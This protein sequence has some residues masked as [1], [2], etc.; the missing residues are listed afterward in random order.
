MKNQIL[1]LGFILFLLPNLLL[2]QDKKA[3]IEIPATTVE[4]NKRG[5][6]I[7]VGGIKVKANKRKRNGEWHHEI[8]KECNFKIANAIIVYGNV[9]NNN[10]EQIFYVKS[11]ARLQANGQG[12][13]IFVEGNAFVHAN[14]MNT[15]V[16]VQSGAEVMANGM[17]ATIYKEPG[18]QLTAKG[19]N[20]RVILC[21]TINF[22]R[23]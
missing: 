18:V 19:M 20:N 12:N 8:E 10:P 15:V 13:S 11:G 14:G 1:F 6:L 17:G 2:S 3:K 23:R 9:V 7:N 4:L 22:Y 16:H 5:V 21:E